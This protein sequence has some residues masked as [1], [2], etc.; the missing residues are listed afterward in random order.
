L[1]FQGKR[2]LIT[3]A[4]KGIGRDLSLL[5]ND[6]GAKVVAVSRDIND[7]DSLRSEIDCEVIQS[8]LSD[9]RSCT[10]LW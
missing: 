9:G 3:G 7:L 5:L 2:A 10:S 8:E 4:G 6:C 1:N